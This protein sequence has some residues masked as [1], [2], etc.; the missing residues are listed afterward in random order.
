MA[1]TEK[2]DVLDESSHE[3][4]QEL[5]IVEKIEPEQKRPRYFI[6]IAGIAVAAI[7]GPT[8]G[9]FITDT[10][11][12]HWIFFINLPIGIISIILTSL[13]VHESEKAKEVAKE[14]IKKAKKVDWLGIFLFVTGIAAL[15]IFLGEGPKKG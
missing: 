14:A 13:F 10:L 2:E 3:S 11:S 6:Y 9:G 1:T 5:S 4:A 8:L 7:L 15:E 12:W